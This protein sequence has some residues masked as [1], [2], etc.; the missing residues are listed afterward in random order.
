MKTGINRP[1]AN[2]VSA[3]TPQVGC[4][5]DMKYQFWEQLKGMLNDIP[6]NK[7]LWITGDINRHVGEENASTS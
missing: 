3:Y 4:T 5:D 7:Q 1:I 6:D 2:I